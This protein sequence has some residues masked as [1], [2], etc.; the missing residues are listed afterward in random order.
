MRRATRRDRATR[1]L[2]AHPHARRRTIA[3]SLAEK[4]APVKRVVERALSIGVDRDLP[5]RTQ[6]RIRLCNLMALGG[7]IIM[8][9]WAYIEAS[10]GERH[11]VPLEL[12]FTA[13]FLAVLVLNLSGAHRAAR[14]LLVAAANAC[15]FAGAVLFTEPSGGL[16]PFF[17]LAAIAV[18][19]FGPEE[20]LLAT[21]GAALPAALFVTCKSGVACP[22]RRPSGTSR[23]TPRRRSC[24]RSWSRSSFFVRA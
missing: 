18:L 21:L 6:K 19:L 3:E 20:W 14:L 8:A 23:P 13:V 24:W 7:A 2:R 17:G 22:A 5:I 11:N 9:A 16:L 10:F 4:F 15:V 12:A 1:R